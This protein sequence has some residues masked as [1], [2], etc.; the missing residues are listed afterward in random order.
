MSNAPSD[1]PRSFG[2]K[3]VRA[4]LKLVANAA[5]VALG[6]RD[7]EQAFELPAR[8]FEQL[9]FTVYVC[10]RDGLVLRYNRRAA[11]LWG[12]SPKLRDPNERFCGSY[13]MFRPDGSLL[14]HDQCPMADVLRTGIS[15]REQE[16]H[17][18]RPDGLRGIALVD[19]EPVKDSEGNVVGAVNCFQ[20]ITERKRSEEIGLRLA[21]IVGS[22]DDAII[23]KDLDGTITSWNG[24][25]ERIFGYLAEEIIGKPIMTLIPP[26]HQ[27]EEEAI[28]GRIRR[29]QRVEHYETIR[30]RKDGSL[31]DISLT[32][33][34]VRSA[35]GK[36][37]GAS[38]IARDITEHKRNEAQIINL[39]REAEH[40]TK[41]I[42]S[43]VLATV[44]LSRADS[45][46]DLKQ[47]IE[48]R[49]DALAKVH[50]LFVQS[51]WTGAE[52]HSLVAQ[53]LL[54]YRSETEG[55]VRI[56]GPPVMLEPNT[57]QTVAISL[58]ELATNAAKYGSLSAA[59]GIVEIAWSHTVDGR[60]SLRWIEAGGPT[61]TPPTHRGFG[62]RVIENMIVGQLRGEVHFDWHDQG[63][64]CEIALP[65]V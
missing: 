42:L 64:T 31:I 62:T 55:R 47:L 25:A 21:A 38:K 1:A 22:S 49:I 34:P 6:L 40:R 51:R 11:E 17:I 28:M 8:L 41:N 2:R 61:V 15:V 50:G 65:L 13:R 10:D 33:S 58:H 37:I 32:I 48:G 60:L 26:D 35:Q 29:G 53:E 36:V 30:Q 27:K 44:R 59:D 5:R 57:A 54:P 56:D 20:D 14:P 23:S 16:V 19:I 3:P 63:L 39:A 52:L 45:S 46:D 4:S 7:E 9:P 12:R 18:D 24:G 43:T